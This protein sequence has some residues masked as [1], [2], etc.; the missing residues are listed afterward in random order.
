MLTYLD[1]PENIGITCQKETFDIESL[2][3]TLQGK[4]NTGPM[5]EERLKR[6][7]SIKK[8]AGPADVMPREEAEYKVRQYCH[9]W[10]MYAD[11]SVELKKKSELSQES[12]VAA[13][14]MYVPYISDITR[15]IEEVVKIFAMEKELRLIKN[16][17]YFPVPQLAPRECKIET[18]QDKDMLMK[19]IDE[20]GVEMLNAIK[21]SEENYREEQEQARIREEQLRSARQNSRSDINLYPTLA[22]STPIRN[23]NTR[24]DQP[25]VHFNTNP[26]HHVYT[27]TSD[28]GEQYEPPENDSIL[29]GATSS[30]ADQFV[31]NAT[32]TAG[33][34]EPWRRNN[35]TNISS[36]TFNHRTTNGPT[37]RNGLQTN[38]PSN[39]TDLRNGPTCFRCG[40]QGHMRG[41]CRKRVFCNHCRSYNHDTKACRKQHDNTQSPVHSQIATGYHPTVTPPPLMGK[42]ATT[43]PT[44]AHNNPLFNLLD[45]NQPRTSTLMHTPQNGTSPA[46]PADLIEGITQIMNRVT[47]NN[48]RDDTSKKMM[49]NIKIFDGSNK[50]ECI[51]WLSQVEAAAKF[52]NTPFRELLCQSM[53][54]AMLHVFSDLSALASDVD[55]KEVILTNYSDIP[56]ST[57]AATRLQN[58][59]FSTNKPLVTFNHRYE[60]L[61]KVAFK[62]SPD[63][64]E[65]KTVIVEYAKKLP[66]NTRD[67]LLRKIA[68]KNSYIKTLDDAFK[69]ALDINRETS[70]VEAATGR[71]ND[72][73]GTNIKTQIN[74]LSD[75]FQEY[76]IKAMNTRS[77]NRSGEGSWNG[78]FDRSSSKNNSFNS[79]QNS[80]S[81]DKSNSYPSNN[82]S[83]NRQ[84]YGRDNSRNRNYQQQPRYKQ[85]NQ[86][87]TNRYDNNQDRNRNDN[88]QDRH[89]FDNRRRPNKYQHHR[90]QH[91]AQVI[92][93]FSDQNVM[94]MM[95]TVRGFINLIKANPTTR[96][97]YKSNKLATRKYDNE[98][99]ES[100][101]QSSSLEQVQEFFNEDS[102]VIFDTL[103]AAD[104]INEI[105]CTDSIC[106]QQA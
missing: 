84:N 7:P 17:G 54:P 45:N 32:G 40:E 42:A 4:D 21:E 63:E 74:E 76:D 18:V 8:L 83:Y 102:D 35:T 96:Q 53:A 22:N 29:Q 19:E 55:I 72:Q 94:E 64:Q 13:C 15:Q 41:E 14:K 50:A 66:A 49:K 80:R 11:S 88:N 34:H 25:G 65:S 103:V 78:S 9:L 26:V 87:Y 105:E 70:F 104:Y 57:E 86:N 89:R 99:N 43:Q 77:T 82:D 60:A 61:H 38:N 90:N 59:Q 39:P 48:K 101:I 100:E 58:I 56:S 67:K 68:K 71:Y 95:Q 28:R 46:A 98:V 16:R 51:T 81:N 47:N 10:T 23:T 12:A 5:Q 69:Q 44:E 85:R 6:I 91:K 20:V 2:R 3:D 106:Q 75:S 1:P 24:T 52:T 92:F 36:N 31:T 27:T 73:S 30:P 79:S 33:R 37:G 97:H 62:M 93:E